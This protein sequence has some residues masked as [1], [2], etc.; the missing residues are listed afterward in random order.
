[1]LKI[2]VPSILS[3]E[4]DDWCGGISLAAGVPI[5]CGKD[6]LGHYVSAPSAAWATPLTAAVADLCE[7]LIPA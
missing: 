1:M 4:I 2:C 5:S 3:S 6:H 7:S